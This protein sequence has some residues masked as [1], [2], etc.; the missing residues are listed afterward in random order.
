MNHEYL[1]RL[2]MKYF[3]YHEIYNTKIECPSMACQCTCIK[4]IFDVH[5]KTK[6]NISWTTPLYSNLRL[7]IKIHIFPGLRHQKYNFLLFFSKPDAC[8]LCLQP[9]CISGDCKS[10]IVFLDHVTKLILSN[11]NK[12]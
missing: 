6:V 12:V 10:R 9:L 7:Y 4:I 8:H 3:L 2:D 11:T 5:V 1:K